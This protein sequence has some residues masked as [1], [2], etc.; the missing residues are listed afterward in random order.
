MQWRRHRLSH[1]EQPH[2]AINHKQN[3][4]SSSS[5]SSMQLMVVTFSMLE[6]KDNRLYIYILY[7]RIYIYIY[8]YIVYIHNY[9]AIITAMVHTGTLDKL[10][11]Q[12]P[13]GAGCAGGCGWR[14]TVW[15]VSSRHE[16]SLGRT[17]DM[18]HS[19]KRTV[20]LRL[21]QQALRL[22]QVLMRIRSPPPSHQQLLPL[23]IASVVVLLMMPLSSAHPL[24]PIRRV[25]LHSLQSI[26]TAAFPNAPTTRRSVTYRVANSSAACSVEL[27]FETSAFDDALPMRV[28]PPHTGYPRPSVR[29]P[30]PSIHTA[31]L[32]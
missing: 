20:P 28:V 14:G 3:S 21:T 10:A 11:S 27:S 19:S 9:A 25:A 5:S 18:H 8:I 15:Q 24:P 13:G 22:L 29:T 7:I 16:A 30:T 1:Q 23:W 12:V 32:F 2:A 4:S 26:P 6:L 31:F 17:P